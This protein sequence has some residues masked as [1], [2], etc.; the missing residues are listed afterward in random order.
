MKDY[1]IDVQLKQ[2]N[3]DILKTNVQNYIKSQNLSYRSKLQENNITY[4]NNL[5]AFK[6]KNHLVYSKKK[7]NIVEFIQ[8]NQVD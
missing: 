1:G 6:D 3:W 8:S 7:E 4:V 5:A 2:V